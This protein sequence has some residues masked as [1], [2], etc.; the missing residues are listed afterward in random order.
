MYLLLSPQAERDKE[1]SVFY[2]GN[3]Q[4][5]AKYLGFAYREKTKSAV[6][7]DA[8]VLTDTTGLFELDTNS[9]GDRNT[10]HLFTDDEKAPGRLGR[11]LS[12]QERM[13]LIEFLKSL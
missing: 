8:V 7:Q 2:L 13:D 6:L 12:A 3:R 11:E 9:H 4:F 5:D 10:G 1:A